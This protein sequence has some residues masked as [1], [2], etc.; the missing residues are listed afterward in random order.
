MKPPEPIPLP[1][2]A[3]VPGRNARH[4]ENLFAAFHD[5]VQP[6]M[7][8]DELA[9]TLAW[10]AG[11]EF[12]QHGFNWEAH[13]VLEPVWMA[14]PEGSDERHFTQALI[15][16]ANAALKRMMGR[17]NAVRRLCSIVEEHLAACG[18]QRCI[19]GL[20]VGAVRDRL[21]ILKV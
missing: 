16:L 18:D 20:E 3:H 14:L 12:I 11:W 19:M 9:R 1:P 5:S 7:G 8:P 17:E 13:E 4:D 2:Y 6:V 21:A 10:R 15:Q